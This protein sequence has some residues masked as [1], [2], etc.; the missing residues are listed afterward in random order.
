MKVVLS[1]QRKLQSLFVSCLFH[2]SSCKTVFLVAFWPE[3]TVGLSLGWWGRSGSPCWFRSDPVDAAKPPSVFF[4]KSTLS[5]SQT[6]RW[7]RSGLVCG[8]A[9]VSNLKGPRCWSLDPNF[10][11]KRAI[12]ENWILETGSLCSLCKM[13][14]YCCI[15]V[16]CPAASGP[17]CEGELAFIRK[18]SPQSVVSDQVVD[19]F[20]PRPSK[21]RKLT[22]TQRDI[23][24]PWSFFGHYI[25]SR[26]ATVEG[27]RVMGLFLPWRRSIFPVRAPR[28]DPRQRGRH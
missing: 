24:V 15:V 1:I 23:L 25:H 11:T 6:S 26:A 2:N 14:A 17:P 4:I 16:R 7:L 27:Q 12:G 20:H 19:W 8:C 28:L 9:A 22:V 10:L 21:L 13:D 5:W 18:L 3:D